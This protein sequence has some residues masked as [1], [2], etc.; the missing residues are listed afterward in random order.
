MFCLFFKLNL[1]AQNKKWYRPN[2]IGF[3]YGI[4]RQGGILLNDK[5]YKYTSN[6]LSLQLN[7]LLKQGYFNLNYELEAAIGFAQH[8][9]LNLYF[10][11]PDES[12]FLDK[13][14][15]FTKNKYLTEL[16]L[17]NNLIFSKQLLKNQ[18]IYI[19]IGFGPM[20]I[21]KRTERLAKGFAF[22]E[23]IGVGLNQKLTRRL[24]FNLRIY[25]RH[26]SNAELKKPNSGINT[27]GIAFGFNYKL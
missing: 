21:S 20:N 6:Q 26:L 18:Q 24:Y 16:L 8:Q 7:Y 22:V 10:I 27:A 5:D 9:L 25:L 23:N 17:I 1:K 11:T 12:D 19:L 2:R 4:G 14:A 15:E 13:R 3:M